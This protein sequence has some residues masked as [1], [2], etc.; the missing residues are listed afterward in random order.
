M[1][2][3]NDFAED[4]RYMELPSGRR[5]Y[6]D[7]P[8]FFIEDI[9][10]TLAG[11]PRFNATARRN[12]RDHS[13]SVAE[14]SVR[15]SYMILEYLDVNCGMEICAVFEG[16]DPARTA[17]L[18]ALMHDAPEAFIGDMPAP[19]KALLPD[20]RALEQRLWVDIVDWTVAETGF[21]MPYKLPQI[22]KE[23]DWRCLFVEAR[24]CMTTQG[25]GW[26]KYE[27]HAP[28]L[29][30]APCHWW[31]PEEATQQFLRRY[32]ELITFDHRD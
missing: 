10:Y 32:Y 12:E 4:A 2:D 20:F 7:N 3:H 22:M 15:A 16:P 19:W 26:V 13:I 18:T 29:S 27:E 9:A 25:R 14:H 8:I 24:E 31:S 23:V 6:I 11:Q 21:V 5:F 30:D 17:A 28:T 1:P